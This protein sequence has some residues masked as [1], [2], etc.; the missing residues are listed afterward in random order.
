MAMPD[1]KSNLEGDKDVEIPRGEVLARVLREHDLFSAQ[2]EKRVDLLKRLEEHEREGQ[3]GKKVGCLAFFSTEAAGIDSA[4]VPAFGDALMSLGD[5]DELDLIINSPGGDG[6]VAE[7]IIEL[8]RAYCK[9]FKVIVPNRA[10]SA[11]TVVAL[12]ADEIIMGYCSELGPI[13]AQVPIVVSGIP[14]YISAQSFID[15]RTTL[16]EKFKNVIKKKEDPRAILQQIASLDAPFIDHC[17]KL[18]EFSQE[19]ARKYLAKYMFSATKPAQAQKEAVDKVLKGLSS[20]SIF[21]VHGRM[22]DG[23]AAKTDLKLNVR[24]L[25]KDAPLWE[26][27]WQYYVR[28]DVTL[29]KSRHALKLIETRN[30]VLIQGM[31]ME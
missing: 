23:N 7:K 5:V 24:L 8:C 11:A 31:R 15:A 9:E 20:V 27:L 16:E 21:K 17:E 29:S 25:A 28:A 14:R 2:R 26:D 1:E 6:T 30:T 4:D 3:S 18:M 12:G 22:I 10:K 19:V 13:D